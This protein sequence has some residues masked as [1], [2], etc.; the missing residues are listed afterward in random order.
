MIYIHA[1]KSFILLLALLASPA[2]AD[3]TGKVVVVA[4][5]D[6]D[7]ITVLRDHVQED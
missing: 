2:W 1:M 3:V 7:T 4:V 6:G 5:A